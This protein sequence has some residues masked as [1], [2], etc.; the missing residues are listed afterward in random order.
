MA[1]VSRARA[2]PL[3]LAVAV[4]TATFPIR[5]LRWRLLLRAADGSPLP[6]APLW[7]AVAIGFMA[8]NL[9]PFR[10]G[11]LVR[12]YAAARL[13]GERLTAAISSVAVER[14]FDG[15]TVVALLSLALFAADLPS[16]LVV[17]GVSVSI[18]RAA[19]IAG[20]VSAAALVMAL[21]VVLAPERAEA[22]IRRVLPAGR[23]TERL[24][25]LIDGF[26]HGLATLRSPGRLAGVVAW[27]VVLWLVNAASFWIAFAAFDL[28][29]GFAGALLLQG[30]LVFGI[31]VPSTPGYVG[32]FEAVIG[33][34]LLLYGVPAS[35]G[36]AYA[37]VYHATT[38]LPIIL[39]G[40]WS[41]L[42]TGLSL[43]EMR[44]EP[45]LDA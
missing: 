25:A 9:L 5:M 35:R 44:R 11:E 31:A 40:A 20:L 34:V 28:P 13:T 16:S 21:A 29:V 18:A 17:G 36:A 26:R 45:A 8:N 7:H 19:W 30:L 32:V 37:L 23:V 33:A 3:L 2:I 38:F 15:L 4:A 14:V 27:S 43:G 10:A 1:E 42:R 24:V 41:L 39:L 22:L 6:A 12:C